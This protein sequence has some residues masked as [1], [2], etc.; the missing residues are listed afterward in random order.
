MLLPLLLLLFATQSFMPHVV[1]QPQPDG[2]CSQVH[3]TPGSPFKALPAKPRGNT[4]AV[5]LP[6][7]VSGLGRD[8]YLGIV[9]T[10]VDRKYENFFY[11]MEV[12]MGV[13][14]ASLVASA[15]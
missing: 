5:L 4:Q 15:G 6:A 1:I 3:K 9:H 8:V 2:T 7:A 11:Q 10:E 14:F 13:G 12:R